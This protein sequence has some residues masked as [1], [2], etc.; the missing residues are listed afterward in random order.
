M[1]KRFLAVA[2]SL[3]LFIS[4]A[5]AD[6]KP[7]RGKFE[8]KLE[9]ATF[10]LYVEKSDGENH[11][12]CT[13][14][15]YEKTKTGYLLVSAGHCIDGR[16]DLKFSVKTDVDDS[17]P[18]MPVTVVKYELD[19]IY[20]FSIL[21]LDTKRLF[22]IIGL[23]SEEDAAVGD[24]IEN[25]SFALGMAKQ[26]NNGYIATQMLHPNDTTASAPQWFLHHFLVEV[27]GAPGSS[28]SAIVSKRSHRIVGLLVS[29]VR[30]EQMGFGV[31]PMSMFYS[32]RS[33]PK[34]TAHHPKLPLETSGSGE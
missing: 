1:M 16:D 4:S 5:V 13:A 24:K 9:N 28:G 25:V 30:D 33:D 31:I 32:F 12:T 27:S 23:G 18:A 6:V 22:P 26:F 2:L 29:G 3:G 11:F 19:D 10:A 34:F 15:A 8:Q 20:D 14:T 17:L 21:Q 7:P